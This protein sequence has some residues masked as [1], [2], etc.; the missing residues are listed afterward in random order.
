MTTAKKIW[1]TKLFMWVVLTICV[2]FDIYWAANAVRGDTISEVTKAYSWKWATIP[3]AYGVLTGHLFW[4]AFGE[5]RWHHARLV[6]LGLVGVAAVTLDFLDYYDMMPIL[7]LVPA[8]ALGRL[9]WP[10][11][12]S[13]KQALFVWKTEK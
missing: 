5:I 7:P 13:A 2:G 12:V 4:S 11:A 9:L 1:F 8:I 6:V 10:Q 3:I